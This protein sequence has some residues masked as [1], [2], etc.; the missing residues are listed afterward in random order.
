MKPTDWVALIAAGVAL[1]GS[2][3]TYLGTRQSTRASK[4][5]SK[6]SNEVSMKLG[7][8]TAEIQGKQRLID[9]VSTQRVEWINKV[10]ENFSE[11]SKVAYNLALVRSKEEKIQEELQYDLYYLI[12][13]IE[14][15]LNPT[16]TITKKF[17]EKKNNLSTY[18]LNDREP[19]S[20]VLYSE[21]MNELHYIEQVILKSEWKRLK[22]ETKSGSEVDDM[23][24]IHK[25]TALKIDPEKFNSI[26]KQD[27]EN[28]A[29]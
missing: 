8:M 28:Q 18:L 14:L 9:T 19:F 5:S 4:E 29:I 25:Q 17:V 22:E 20:W 23:E 15:S 6:L 13:H 3:L 16:E 24:I 10:R 11:F 1:I 27:F 21:F 2:L 26:L 7:N 12:N